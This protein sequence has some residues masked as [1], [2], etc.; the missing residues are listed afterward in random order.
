MPPTSLAK[1]PT[2]S[3]EGK[4]DKIIAPG[5]PPYHAIGVIHYD[6]ADRPEDGDD[7]KDKKDLKIE[8]GYIL[9]I[10]PAYHGSKKTPVLEATRRRIDI[11]ARNDGRSVVHRIAARE[12]PLARAGNRQ[13]H[14][15]PRGRLRPANPQKGVGTLTLH[16]ALRGIT[17]RPSP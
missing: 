4:G 7:A 11:S 5:E 8:N 10:K 6:E 15:Q 16:D 13:P 9:Y 17:V 14:S 3:A 12:L 2:K 1:S